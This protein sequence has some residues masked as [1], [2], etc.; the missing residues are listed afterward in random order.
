MFIAHSSQLRRK[1][2]FRFCLFFRYYLFIYLHNFGSILFHLSMNPK[3]PLPIVEHCL[4]VCKFFFSSFVVP[5]FFLS[6]PESGFVVGNHS[7][8]HFGRGL[9][10]AFHSKKRITIISM[11]APHIPINV[12]YRI[13]YVY[14]L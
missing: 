10:M 6:L 14:S 1:F 8:V 5:F 3:N 13:E 4:P 9:M 7:V 2:V 12:V 11:R